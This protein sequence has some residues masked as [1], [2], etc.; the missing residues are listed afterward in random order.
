MAGLNYSEGRPIPLPISQGGT[1]STSQNF[2]DLST[3]Q[4]SIAGN[5]GFTGSTSLGVGSSNHTM[6]GQN[7]SYIFD[8]GNMH[9]DPNGQNMWLDTSGT[10]LYIGAGGGTNVGINNSSPGANLD[11]TGTGHFSS[12]LTVGGLFF[13][14]QAPTASAPSYVKG[15]IY[16]DTTLNKLR[17][18]G[19][20]GWETITSV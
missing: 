17:V 11:V 7:S 12:D 3:N 18:G 1:G 19:A 14:E 9:I 6:F 4:A 15:A 5:K 20:T 10:N 8:D 13:P 2:V 16:F